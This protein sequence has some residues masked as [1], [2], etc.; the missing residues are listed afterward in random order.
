LALSRGGGGSLSVTFTRVSSK[1][2]CSAARYCFQSALAIALAVSSWGDE[3]MPELERIAA[4]RVVRTDREHG[5]QAGGGEPRDHVKILT[6]L[7]LTRA[8]PGCA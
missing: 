5:E 4:L 7:D 3:R 6:T 1:T 2:R 8:L